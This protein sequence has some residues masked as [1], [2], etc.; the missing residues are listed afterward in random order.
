MLSAA[1]TA[2]V[3]K[4][5]EYGGPQIT[6]SFNIK[7]KFEAVDCLMVLRC[8]QKSQSEEAQLTLVT[9]RPTAFFV[10]NSGQN[11][12]GPLKPFTPQ[13]WNI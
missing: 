12:L 2:L 11:F 9:S 3:Q 13:P 8:Q 10:W 7:D 1:L 5:T 4:S 6:P